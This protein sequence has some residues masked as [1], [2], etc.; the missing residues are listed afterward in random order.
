MSSSLLSNSEPIPLVETEEER[1]SHA[2]VPLMETKSQSGDSMDHDHTGVYV[3]MDTPMASSSDREPSLVP[4][5]KDREQRARETKDAEYVESLAHGINSFWALVSPV[6]L[7][8]LLTSF[9]VVHYQSE[10]LQQSMSSYLIYKEDAATLPPVAGNGS[11]SSG[12]SSSSNESV[13]QSLVNALA[14][15]GG[16]AGMTFV[17]V[18]LYKYNCMKFLVGYI[19]FASTG[20]LGF[21]GGQ[22]AD[23]ILTDNFGWPVDWISFL[24]ILFNFSLVGVVSIFYQ[25]GTP[26]ILQQGYLVL[27]SVILAWQFS[28]W[29]EWT[30]FIFCSAFAIYD[31][32]AVLTPC[33]PL[34]CLIGLIQEKQQPMPGLLYEATVR[35]GISG[36]TSERPK[37]KKDEG[38]RNSKSM[39]TTTSVD[40]VTEPP[41]SSQPT[42]MS[43]SKSPKEC[44]VAGEAG[45]EEYPDEPKYVVP[46]Y[47]PTRDSIEDFEAELRLFYEL[48]SEDDVWKAPDAA[49]KFFATQ[50]HMWPLMYHKYHV[51]SCTHSADACLVRQNYEK[52]RAERQAEADDTTIKL[53]LGDF[54]FYSVL[55]GRAA[56]FDFSTFVVTFVAIIMGLGATLFLLSVLHKALPALPFSIFTATLF[57]FWTRYTFIDYLDAMLEMG[58]QLHSTF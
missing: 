29:P 25:K 16:V 12:D 41:T 24:F 7:T 23:I 2:K 15:I 4:Q 31:L 32:C 49:K 3:E 28:A 30:T 9:V 52:R 10:A 14:I 22:L 13:W 56:L 55:V 48:Y 53:G 26:Q 38:L 54:I 17:M 50:G 36:A 5:Q 42:E 40:V 21:E 20:I 37:K 1:R 57:Y 46:D 47:P 43:E 39:I 34:K 27:T 45:G 33:G 35:D 19:M 18:L 58:H 51:C 44:R 8:M 6:M 11:S